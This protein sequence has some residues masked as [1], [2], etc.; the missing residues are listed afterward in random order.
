MHDQLVHEV[1]ELMSELRG[2]LDAGLLREVRIPGQPLR[3]DFTS[4]GHELAAST[5]RV[6]EWEMEVQDEPCPVCGATDGFDGG[7][8]CRRC[9]V[10]WPPE[11]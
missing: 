1:D 10:S 4:V 9:Y 3:I 7:G 6:S 11:M 2:L 8:R 5:S